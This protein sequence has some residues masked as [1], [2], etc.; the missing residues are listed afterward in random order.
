MSQ[1]PW[2]K[3]IRL[4]TPKSGVY[5]GYTSPL[6]SHQLDCKTCKHHLLFQA[7]ITYVDLFRITYIPAH[8]YLGTLK[9][10]AVLP[11]A[12]VPAAVAF[13]AGQRYL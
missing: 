12:L 2:T 11:G 3:T 1:L 10:Q 7:D 9:F 6:T 8:T 13:S 5:L 4:S